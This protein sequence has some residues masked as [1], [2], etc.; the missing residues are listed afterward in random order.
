MRHPLPRRRTLAAPMAFA[1]L[2]WGAAATVW[3]QAA[4]VTLPP[5]S[6]PPIPQL[7]LQPLPP[8]L[9]NLDPSRELLP[10]PAAP[11]TT[12]PQPGGPESIAPPNNAAP[13]TPPGANQPA[14]KVY[15]ADVLTSLDEFYPLLVAVAQERGISAG[16][17]LA[18]EG[19][20]DTRL[21]AASISQPLGF[22]KNY[23]NSV[24][25]EQPTWKGGKVTAGYRI[26]DGDFAPWYGE[27]ETN[28]G[29]EFA[30]GAMVPFWKDR[31]I[32][33]RRAELFK[34]NI[35]TR[36]AEPKIRKAHI[37][38]AQQASY[39]YWNWVAA[40]HSENVYREYL[41]AAVERDEFIRLGVARGNVAEIER[42]DNRRLIASREANV[43]SA[44]RKTRKAAIDMSLFLRDPL[45]AQ[46][47]IVPALAAPDT[48]PPPQRPNMDQLNRDI[49]LALLLNP[50][51]SRL[52]LE[53]EKTNV[54]LNYAKNL[55]LPELDG[56]LYAS[57]DVGAPASSKG[58]KTPFELE[59]GL[60]FEVPLQRRLGWGEIRAAESE[61]AR[62]RAE[63]QYAADFVTAK[64]RDAVIA[65]DATYERIDIAK[66]AVELAKQMETAERRRFELGQSNILFVN[67]REANTN[68]TEISL[69]LAYAD[70][71]LALADYRAALSANTAD[72]AL[73][74]RN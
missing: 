63:E 52:R 71:F 67:L 21:S 44:Q 14:R 66:R 23:R 68:E 53:R 32:D 29:G 11:S 34:A 40:I 54:Q 26:G 57:K 6:F 35:K 47:L 33:K 45:T 55:T 16:E 19:A 18:A 12:S 58:D 48:F 59:A 49:D 46:P 27:R 38:F 25:I 73:G 8:L 65:L 56:G 31:V 37:N 1:V 62:L 69:I 39:A 30:T 17:L 15:L 10:P 2:L 4:P 70:Y 20:F 28:E 3:G 36:L 24:G 64:V 22:Y 9:N 74:N 42:V 61:M 60:Y 43:I 5:Q 50:E 7:Q 41:Q 13:N 51:I 72:M